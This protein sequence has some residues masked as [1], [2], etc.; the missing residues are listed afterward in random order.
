MD[1]VYR[2][3]DELKPYE[4]NPR[5]NDE[6]VDAVAASIREFG[7]R[8]PIVID[9]S[10]VIV[11]GHTRYKALKKL[12]VLRIPCVMADDLTDEQIRAYRLADNK[13]GELADWDIGL[14]DGELEGILDLDM[15]EFGFEVLGEE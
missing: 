1:I 8:Q 6:A 3:L 9:K 7:F 2:T 14:L 11:C 5:K 13:T 12:G 4:K 15:S 10:N